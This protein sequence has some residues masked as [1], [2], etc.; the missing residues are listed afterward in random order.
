MNQ[1]DLMELLKNLQQ[2]EIEI[3]HLEQDLRTYHPSTEEHK[4]ADS[5][6][7]DAKAIRDGIRAKIKE[8]DK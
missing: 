1:P 4:L 5:V 6:L 2:I 3:Y 8:L 7:V